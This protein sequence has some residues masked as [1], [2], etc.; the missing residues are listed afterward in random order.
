MKRLEVYLEA[1]FDAF[2]ELI[3]FIFIIIFLI[4]T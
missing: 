2:M 1:W 4:P 3:G